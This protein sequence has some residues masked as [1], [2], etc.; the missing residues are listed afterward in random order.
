MARPER[1]QEYY[2]QIKDKFREQRDLR[3]VPPLARINTPDFS[4]GLAN[5]IDPY[6]KD[7]NRE[8]ISDAVEV[9]F[10]GGGFSAC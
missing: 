2:D 7:L 10:I 5:A 3:L 1:P 9:L 4:G 6:A 8:P